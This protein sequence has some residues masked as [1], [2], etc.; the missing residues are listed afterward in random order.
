MNDQIREHWH[1]V[2]SVVRRIAPLRLCDADRDD[3]RQ[4]GLIGLWQ[5][6]EHHDGRSCGFATFATS[7]IKRRIIDG[8][9]QRLGRSRPSTVEITWREEPAE[10]DLELEDADD[11][12]DA[13]AVHVALAH[14][15]T[16]ER[17]VLALMVWEDMTCAEIGEVIGLTSPG[18]WR[19]RARGLEQLRCVMS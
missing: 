11:R 9:R 10:L 5:A 1:L 15:P 17:F 18:V 3:M 14:L 16:I 6:L 19:A 2:D 4:D 12:L 7:H 13:R 8:F